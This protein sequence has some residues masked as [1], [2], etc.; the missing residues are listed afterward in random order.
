MDRDSRTYKVN[1][2]W[3][4]AMP[5][6]A[7]K[8]EAAEAAALARQTVEQDPRDWQ[9]W[10]ALGAAQYRMG[11]WEQAL[12]ALGKAVELTKSGPPPT[13]LFMAM[14]Q[15]RLGKQEP[16]RQRYREVAQFID[17]SAKQQPAWRLL[18]TECAALL[19]IPEPPSP[20][21]KEAPQ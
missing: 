5:V 9:C 3:A 6:A 4:L 8:Q 11:E 18:R 16:A 1:L 14:A 15:W 2:A 13:Y 19:G 10:N 20:R 21:D 17:K 12:Q 7:T